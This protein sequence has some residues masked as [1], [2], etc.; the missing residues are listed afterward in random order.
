MLLLSI[1]YSQPKWTL[2]WETGCTASGNQDLGF[3]PVCGPAW[4]SDPNTSVPLAPTSSG[5]PSLPVSLLSSTHKY[6]WDSVFPS[7]LQVYSCSDS[8][9]MGDQ[10]S[11]FL[12]S[13][14]KIMIGIPH[15]AIKSRLYC[16]GF[17]F[18]SFSPTY[19]LANSVNQYTTGLW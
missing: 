1:D 15:F 14:P 4:L 7:T 5:F 18:L 16:I 9:L 8:L 17:I 3:S 2:S 13:S 12:Q 6:P 11:P 10:T 19:T